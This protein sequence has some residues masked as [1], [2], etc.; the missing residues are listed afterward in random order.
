MK[1]YLKKKKAS[2]ALLNS[3]SNFF[4][5]YFNLNGEFYIRSGFPWD[6]NW[7]APSIGIQS[8]LFSGSHQLI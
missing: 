4:R 1:G 3:P 2:D 6:L 8:S 5:L 7:H